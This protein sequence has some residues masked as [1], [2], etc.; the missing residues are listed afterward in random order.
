MLT[1]KKSL[2]FTPDF[3]Q[4]VSHPQFLRY[5]GDPQ[6]AQ[7]QSSRCNRGTRRAWGREGLL[8]CISDVPFDSR[9]WVWWKMPGSLLQQ[10]GFL[11]DPSLPSQEWMGPKTI[12]AGKDQCVQMDGSEGGGVEIRCL[13][14]D[15]TNWIH[16]LLNLLGPLNRWLHW[17]GPRRLMGLVQSIWR[18]CWMTQ[19]RSGR[20]DS[21]FGLLWLTMINICFYDIG[22][23]LTNI[24][25]TPSL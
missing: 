2:P 11:P 18:D 1:S 19:F 13:H 16:Q 17:L 6:W 10:N 21:S 8:G 15:V 9:T 3:P 20:W 23:Q 14:T 22:I 7:S 4:Q 12:G 24:W 5:H 25:L